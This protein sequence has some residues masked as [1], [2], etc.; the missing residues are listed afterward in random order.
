MKGFH[1]YDKSIK[2]TYKIHLIYYLRFLPGICADPGYPR[3]FP[4]SP[5]CYMAWLSAAFSDSSFFSLFSASGRK[6]DGRKNHICHYFFRNVISFLLCPSV[7]PLR[8]AARRRRLYGNCHQP[9]QSRPYR[10]HRI[11]LQISQAPGSESL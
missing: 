5:G 11:Y 8:Q 10:L 7:G 1:T 4:A 3:A 6:I 9:D 2:Q